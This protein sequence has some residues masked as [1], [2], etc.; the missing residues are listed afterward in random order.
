MQMSFLTP[1]VSAVETVAAA[2]STPTHVPGIVTGVASFAWSLVGAEV[3]GSLLKGTALAGLVPLVTNVLGVWVFS[4]LVVRLTSRSPTKTWVE[5][6]PQTVDHPRG[7]TRV[8]PDFSSPKKLEPPVYDAPVATLQKAAKEWIEQQPRTAIVTDKEGYIYAYFLTN[9]MGF[10]DNFAV[11][12][13]SQAGGKTRVWVQ[14]ELI[15][16]EGDL[17]VNYNRVNAFLSALGKQF[18]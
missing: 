12:F 10:R 8:A 4:L 2:T 17:G 3:V 7:A 11:K 1:A 13:E 15:L 9:L 18:K 16:G 5:D 6:F 14:S